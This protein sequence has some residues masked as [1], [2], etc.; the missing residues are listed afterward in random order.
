LAKG[1]PP[2]WWCGLGSSSSH[3]YRRHPEHSRNSGGAKSL[4]LSEAEGISREY[5]EH[6]REGSREIPHPAEVRRVSGWRLLSESLGIKPHQYRASTS[7]NIS[8]PARARKDA[9]PSP[10]VRIRARP[11][12]VYYRRTKLFVAGRSE[13]HFITKLL[14]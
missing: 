13:L 6:D 1:N 4:P 10:A 2:T 8:R 7:R 14:A 3:F 9:L 11:R 5:R 12:D